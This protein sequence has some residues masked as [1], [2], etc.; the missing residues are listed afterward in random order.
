MK[1]TYEFPRPAL[2]VDCAIFG[3]D[4][5]DLNVLLIERALPPFEGSWALPGGFVR[6]DESVD[7]A[8]RRELSEET[9]LTKVYLE[10]LYTFGTPDRDPR[11]RVVTVAYFALVKLGSEKLR[12]TTDARSARWFPV[13]KIPTLA[14]DHPAILA[15]AVERLK[16]KVRYEPIGFELLPEKF[17]LRELQH[18]Y[19]VTLGVDIDKRN[20]RRKILA[21]GLVLPL[22][23]YE[24]GVRHRAA[25]LHRFDA[26]RYRELHTRGFNFEL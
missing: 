25:E 9:G 20:F 2:T 15:K 4:G 23:E 13:G 5:G 12:A 18:L 24:E 10:Q 17:T 22:A 26:D 14:F 19:E 7:D 8:A 1:Y 11:G 16:S 21:M 6:M 3:F